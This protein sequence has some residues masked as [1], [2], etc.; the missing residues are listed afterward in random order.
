MEAHSIE[1]TAKLP[2]LARPTKASS[3]HVKGTKRVDDHLLAYTRLARLDAKEIINAVRVGVSAKLLDDLV[4]DMDVPRIRI[5]SWMDIPEATAKR[6]IRAGSALSKAVG[7]QTL[8]LARL[9][10]Q[11][12]R[13]VA[14]SGNL[15]SFDAAVWLAGWLS[16]PNAALGGDLPGDY[17]DTAEG[18]NLISATLA[19]MQ[20]GAYA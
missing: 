10:G 17:M 1:T 19:R 20:S 7:E 5:L 3:R 15:K 14:E 8:G 18:R 9:I 2:G 16:E 6:K 4:R 11:V 12:Q 13:M